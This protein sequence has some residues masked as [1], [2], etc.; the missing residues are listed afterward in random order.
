MSAGEILVTAATPVF[1]GE[2]GLNWTDIGKD[3]KDLKADYKDLKTDQ[4]DL[5]NDK[6]RSKTR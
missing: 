1:A 2:T 6:L 5:K 3:L 4:A